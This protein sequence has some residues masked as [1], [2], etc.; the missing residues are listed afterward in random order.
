MDC[1]A[2]DLRSL[3]GALPVDVTGALVEAARTRRAESFAPL[4]LAALHRGD[5]L[6]AA[7]FFRQGAP[8]LPDASTLA[9][10]AGHL[11][12]AVGAALIG[13]AADG[14]LG[15]DLEAVALL[16]AA[17]WGRARGEPDPPELLRLARV[18]ARRAPGG[19]AD[20]VLCA[21]LGLTD[22][23]GLEA[24]LGPAL[25]EPMRE[26]ARDVAESLLARFQGPVLD[27]V[28][29]LPGSR[30]TTGTI[31]RATAKVG[32]NSPCPCGSGKKYK[33]CHEKLDAKR[34][35]DAS[36]V[37][38]VTRA[39][40]R[41]ALGAHL[42]QDKL[43]AL[44]PHELIRVD[45]LQLPEAL[46][47]AW[48]DRL[49]F[50]REWEALEQAYGALDDATL[51]PVLID[52]VGDAAWLG[53]RDAARALLKRHH[54]GDADLSVWARLALADDDARVGAIAEAAVRA[55]LDGA[56]IE[57]AYALLHGPW[58]SLGVLAAR[59]VLPHLAPEDQEPLLA[60]LLD[61]REQ[62]GL[63]PWDPVE[64][65]LYKLSHGH[66]ADVAAELTRAEQQ[67]AANQA[68]LQ[69][70]TSELRELRRALEARERAAPVVV[71]RTTE[72]VVEDPE[73]RALRERV[74]ELK[75]EL[76]SRHAE[77]NALR[78]ELTELKARTAE[79]P[80]PQATEDEVDVEDEV[81]DG[82]A[83]VQHDGRL[84]FPIWT[85]TFRDTLARVPPN[86]ARAAVDKLCAVAVG[87]QGAF[88]EVRRLRG[89]EW[90]WRA[91]VGRSYRLLFRM[92]PDEAVALDLVHRQD[93]EKRIKQLGQ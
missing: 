75:E 93:L 40:L 17:F 45:P 55:A 72:R 31:Q 15:W 13:A 56:P 6:D 28:P 90:L 25:D 34:E 5:A 74:A 1:N 3:A 66:D 12:G 70:A 8:L 54:G 67:I 71:E 30:A 77:R 37:A 62:L 76:K 19:D 29:D 16:L 80:E 14:K 82:D 84:R 79:E 36:D 69:G 87:N 52:H 9:A 81:E 2:R 48:L 65:V 22:D 53:D 89:R 33:Q 78:R 49:S 59:A 7:A 88:V 92:E 57:A 4:L 11:Q 86:V 42:T 63:A 35:L 60:E 58:P 61:T 43:D 26:D 85:E 47:V 27:A 39:E 18:L 23:A 10:A 38:G 44:R 73:A 50:H 83:D 32:R 41:R 24:G 51:D 68:R 20:V 46:V 91:K 64:Q 21:L